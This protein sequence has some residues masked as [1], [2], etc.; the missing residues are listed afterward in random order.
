MENFAA[1]QEIPLHINETDPERITVSARELHDYLEVDTDYPHWFQRM[2]EYGFVEGQDF[3]PVKNV[4][5]QYEGDRTVA[6][7]IADA[8]ITIEMAKE[9]CMLQRSEK[10]TEARKYFIQLE[11]ETS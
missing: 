3:N 2:S 10:G 1:V 8:Q 11:K 7:E 4:R 6:R 5:V 9:L